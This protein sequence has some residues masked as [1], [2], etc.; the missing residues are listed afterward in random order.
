MRKRLSLIILILLIP[1]T[2]F[3]WGVALM[4]LPGGAGVT[5]LLYA[6]F[7]TGDANVPNT[8]PVPGVTTGSYVSVDTAGGSVDIDTNRAK[9]TGSGTVD[10]TG[11]MS[12]TAI[13][14]AA[15]RGLFMTV[16]N[17]DTNDQLYAGYQDNATLGEA[18]RLWGIILQN[19]SKI[20][21]HTED[22]E[23][24]ALESIEIATYAADTEYK[25]VQVSG[26]YSSG[27]PTADGSGAEGQSWYLY[28]GSNYELMWRTHQNSDATIYAYAQAIQATS[29]TD[30]NLIP[31]T[32]TF[33]SCI[34]PVFLDLF[35]DDNATAIASHVPDTN[36]ESATWADFV[37]SGTGGTGTIDT[38]TLKFVS[39]GAGDVGGSWI[40]SGVSDGIFRAKLKTGV[41]GSAAYLIIRM[42]DSDDFIQLGVFVNDN[43]MYLAKK[44][45]GAATTL[46]SGAV[47]GG[48]AAN[49]WYTITVIAD[50]DSITGYCDGVEYVSATESDHQT[51]T[52][53]GLLEAGGDK[54][55][56]M[57]NLEVYSRQ[58]TTYN[59][60]FAKVGY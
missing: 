19:D 50:G 53:V 45:G 7:T 51:E 43:K 11:I 23:S 57:D 42:K 10:E 9:L 3:A 24:S 6:P 15:G 28:D 60:E 38:N 46:D 14:N 21:A 30:L 52:G 36:P 48:V 1:A 4:G 8:D 37:F 49:T 2:L 5:Y 33:E 32:T 25:I 16:E 27:V 34:T 22:G 55:I 18:N 47:T 12:T 31:N 17:A 44:V 29:F 35:T 41:T 54:T 20:Y 13:T 39:D 59:T 56:Y 40:D 58:S 26:G